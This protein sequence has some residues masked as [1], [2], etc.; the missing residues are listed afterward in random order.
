MPL[1]AAK[2]TQDLTCILQCYDSA[3]LSVLSRTP[4]VLYLETV[5]NVAMQWLRL[6]YLIVPELLSAWFLLLLLYHLGRTIV[7]VES[8]IAGRGLLILVRNDHQRCSMMDLRSF[9]LVVLDL[10]G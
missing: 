10:V 8:E 7:A 2:I 9:E 4:L 6:S 3:A 1:W 5:D